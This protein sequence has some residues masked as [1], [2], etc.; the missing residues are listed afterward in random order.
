MSTLYQDPSLG[1]TRGGNMKSIISITLG[2]L[3]LATL[4]PAIA[5]DQGNLFHCPSEGWKE[6]RDNFDRKT[7]ENAKYGVNI[8][9]QIPIDIVATNAGSEIKAVADGTIYAI[10]GSVIIIG[11]ENNRWFSTTMGKI[12]PNTG[13]ENPIEVG[14]SVNAGQRIAQLF[15]EADTYSFYVTYTPLI[16]EYVWERQLPK[17]FTSYVPRFISHMNEYAPNPVFNLVHCKN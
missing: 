5:F 2:L 15:S 3:L 14:K 13:G 12:I 7:Y 16:F 1:A 8:K 9:H 6:V 11:H 10:N 17:P 4:R